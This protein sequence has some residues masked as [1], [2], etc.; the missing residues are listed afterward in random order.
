[1]P[2]Q[3]SLHLLR[4]VEKL[5]R[6]EV[7]VS[8]SD[9]VI[10]YSG[11]QLDETQADLWMYLMHKA[12]KQPLGEMI[13]ASRATI[14]KAIGRADSKAQYDWL[15]RSMNSLSFAM[16]NIETYKDGGKTKKLALTRVIHLID[17]FDA[18][19]ESGDYLFYVD[20]RWEEVYANEYA[21][22]NWEQRKQISQGQDMAKSIQRLVATSSNKEQFY[23]LDWLKMKLGYTSPLRKFKLA[24]LSAVSELERVGIITSGAFRMSTRDTEQIV[25]I[26]P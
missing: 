11:E 25:I 10:K 9:A 15:L 22:I 13:Y 14:L 5:L 24:L 6:E 21:L 8:R 3:A 4:E 7:L 12:S 17:G 23:S 19:H 20:T 16:L 2:G 18:N 26:K 1:M